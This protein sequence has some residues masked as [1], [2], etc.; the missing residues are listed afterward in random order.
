MPPLIVIAALLPVLGIALGI[1]WVNQITTGEM[2]AISVSVVI[3]I[4]TVFMFFWRHTSPSRAYKMTLFDSSVDRLIP[5]DGNEVSKFRLGQDGIAEVHVRIITKTGVNIEKIRF[6]LVNKV[7]PYG[8]RRWIAE[9]GRR[10][11]IEKIYHKDLEKESKIN[12]YQPSRGAPLY[13]QEDQAG[14]LLFNNRRFLKGDIIWYRV[15]IHASEEWNGYLEFCGPSGDNRPAYS[16]RKI[17][18]Q[19]NPDKGDSQT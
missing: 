6:R 15:I 4:G 14:I 16:R 1:D 5:N 13:R 19:L 7:C 18:L 2:I 8:R 17:T 3:V 10:G 9:R 12:P 11:F